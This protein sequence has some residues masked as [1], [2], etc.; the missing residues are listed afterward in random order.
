MI[1]CSQKLEVLSTETLTVYYEELRERKVCHAAGAMV[2][3]EQLSLCSRETS[4]DGRSELRCCYCH[5]RLVMKDRSGCA[6]III[7][8]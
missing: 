5:S 2:M 6:V 8:H 1:V 7:I 3:K 4:D